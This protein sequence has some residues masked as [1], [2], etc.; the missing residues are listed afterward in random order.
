MLTT[1]DNPINPF[2]NFISWW[3]NDLLLGHDCCGLLARFALTSDIFSDQ[4][5]EE[6]I[7]R[8]MDEICDRYPLIYRKVRK[9]DYSGLQQKE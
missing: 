2:D 5:N 9:S 4:K 3:K 1:Y 6:E 7:D 8:A